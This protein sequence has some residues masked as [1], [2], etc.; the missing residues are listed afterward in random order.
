MAVPSTVT[1]SSHG[2]C[3]AVTADAATGTTTAIANREKQEARDLNV[4]PGHNSYFLHSKDW[5]CVTENIAWY[6]LAIEEK[7]VLPSVMTVKKGGQ[8]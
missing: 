3:D 4:T 2:A 7:K 1:A 5:Q 8:G 6:C